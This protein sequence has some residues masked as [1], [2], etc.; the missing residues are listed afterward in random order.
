[1]PL[2]LKINR[3]LLNLR[4]QYLAV[5]RRL[6]CR[7]GAALP[8]LFDDLPAVYSPQPGPANDHYEW[9]EGQSTSSMSLTLTTEISKTAPETYSN[10]PNLP[11]KQNT[12]TGRA[13]ESLIAE[14]AK[15]KPFYECRVCK[16]QFI[17]HRHLGG[18]R[19]KAHLN[20]F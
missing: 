13:E 8:D 3:P 5:L 20:L 18:H 2:N 12:N 11:V 1:M 16:K 19:S 9:T 4:Y 17:S 10:F 15:S 14:N 6:D 7:Y